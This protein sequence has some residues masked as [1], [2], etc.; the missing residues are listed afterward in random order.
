[1]GKRHKE[2]LGKVSV[3]EPVGMLVT[4]FHQQLLSQEGLIR[5][6][7]KTGC[8]ELVAE[9]T[10]CL[11]ETITQMNSHLCWQYDVEC[12]T[13]VLMNSTVNGNQ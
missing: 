1:M 4:A 9:S 7:A 11:Y 6:R 2:C 3:N 10:T 8:L 5:P 12:V 13:F